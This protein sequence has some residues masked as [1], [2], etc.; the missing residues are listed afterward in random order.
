MKIQRFLQKAG[1]LPGTRVNRAGQ[2]CNP[3]PRQPVLLLFLLVSL[4]SCTQ[5]KQTACTEVY[6]MLTVSVKDS[7]ANPVLLSSYYMKKTATGEIIDFAGENPFTDSINRIHGIYTLF[8]DGKMGMT[9]EGGTRFEFHGMK[10]STEVVN[11]PYVI[12][13][14]KCHVK[15][16]AGKTEITV[17]K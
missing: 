5:N 3:A 10:G 16:I 11:S 1:H 9:A 15:L 17:I 12:G 6:T 4:I 2:H 13:N 8:T 14:D 7:A